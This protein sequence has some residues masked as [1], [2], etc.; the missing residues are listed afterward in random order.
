M[1]NWT[2][3][4]CAWLALCL[5]ILALPLEA[6]AL[7]S[8]YFTK[9][10]KF[11]K[12][13]RWKEGASYGDNQTPKSYS[14]N[15]CFSCYAYTADFLSNWNKVFAGVA[16]ALLPIIVIYFFFSE[17]ITAGMTSGSIKG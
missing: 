17:Q 12:D 13:A 2:R 5:L 7:P 14:T 6:F 4:A 10:D 11:I 9:V 15:S 1:K 3:F 8:D 16:I